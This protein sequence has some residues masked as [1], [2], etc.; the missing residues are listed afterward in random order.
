[1]LGHLLRLAVLMHVLH[2]LYLLH[3]TVTNRVKVRIAGRDSVQ[4]RCPTCWLGLGLGGLRSGEVPYLL[5]IIREGRLR[6]G[7]A[8]S[9]G[10]Y[11]YGYGC[12]YRYR[13]RYRYRYEYGRVCIWVWV[14]VW[15]QVQIRVWIQ[16][17][18]RVPHL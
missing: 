10:A 11:G 3:M 12:G 17:Q 18:G 13:H 4:E 14:Q 1:M 2:L 15:I 8:N 9:K 6:L 5:V 16:V 7:R